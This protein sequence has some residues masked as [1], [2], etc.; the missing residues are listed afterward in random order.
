MLFVV[1]QSTS[2]AAPILAERWETPEDLLHDDEDDYYDGSD[3][4]SDFDDNR[5]ES[6]AEPG[7]EEKKGQ[8]LSLP[9]LMSK[10]KASQVT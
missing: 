8:D 4:D 10:A 1:R 5:S 6:S 9:E 3:D 7:V 2:L